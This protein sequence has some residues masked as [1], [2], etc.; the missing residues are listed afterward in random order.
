MR[1][2]VL[3]MEMYFISIFVR[4]L[5]SKG[6]NPLSIMFLILFLLLFVVSLAFFVSK[7]YSRGT[8]K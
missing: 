7:Y 6:L 1:I 2:I 8:R 4:S 5:I 3:I